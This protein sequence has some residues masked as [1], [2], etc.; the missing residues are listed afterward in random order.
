MIC[1]YSYPAININSNINISKPTNPLPTTKI[2][3]NQENMTRLMNSAFYLTLAI[4][5][6]VSFTPQL[7]N[8]IR[9]NMHV[10]STAAAMDLP[11]FLPVETNEVQKEEVA[12]RTTVSKKPE[13]KKKSITH[14]GGI[15]TPV[16]QM[17]K[18]VLGEDK[19]NKLRAKVISEHSDVIS[20]FVDTADTAFGNTVLK[21]LFT[22]ADKDKNGTIESNELR[23]VMQ[24]LRFDWIKEKQ[25]QGIF[26]RADKDS[27]GK[28]D[29]QEWIL[30][31]PKTLRTN[32]IKLA[33]KNGGELGFLS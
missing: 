20:K 18:I 23:D 2:R 3:I 12:T 25:M 4:S 29:L 17:T 8:D 16:V 13:M 31:A 28:I 14:S 7:P 30:E 9:M 21:Q 32:L 19:L 24:S 1:S 11:Y 22:L 6:A 10:S 27:N 15:F 5:G 33:K 26:E